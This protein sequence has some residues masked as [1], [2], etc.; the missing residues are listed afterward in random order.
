MW[1]FFTLGLLFAIVSIV[2][3][4]LINTGWSSI[5]AFFSSITSVA[6]VLVITQD[7]ARDGPQKMKQ[8]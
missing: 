6:S 1:I 8:D 2:I 7:A 5:V 3:Y 4:P